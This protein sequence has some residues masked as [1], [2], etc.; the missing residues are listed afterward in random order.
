MKT[1]KPLLAVLIVVMSQLLLSC[2]PEHGHKDL[3]IKT[4]LWENVRYKTEYTHH[5]LLKKLKATDRNIVFYYDENKKL[6]KA[7][8]V[9]SGS[10]SPE[11]VLEYVQG[12]KGITRITWKRDGSVYLI[13][14]FT[15][16]GDGRITK[17]VNDFD[18]S[19][20]DPYAQHVLALTYQGN[21][22][23]KLVHSVNGLD[24][25]LLHTA[26]FDDKKSPFRMLAKSVNNTAFFPVGNYRFFQSPEDYNIPYITW[27]SENNPGDLIYQTVGGGLYEVY[28]MSYIYS[29]DL[30]T[31]ITWGYAHDQPYSK[32]FEFEYGLY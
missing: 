12:P 19:T 28:P 31:R 4:F 15:Y 9:F 17:I 11:S 23:S 1:T 10:S 24:F 7:E 2:F 20:D 26:S 3:R 14:D 13:T 8:I 18:P 22:V 30:V 32:I 25:T 27:L 16:A 6:Y 5:G 29:H 21:N